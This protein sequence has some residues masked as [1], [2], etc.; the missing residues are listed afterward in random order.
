[1]WEAMM[2]Y[3]SAVNSS[4]HSRVDAW[5]CTFS[6]LSAPVKPAYYITSLTHTVNNRNLRTSHHGSVHTERRVLVDHIHV[7]EAKRVRCA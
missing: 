6:H 2:V 3:P 1:M 5:C 4:R 7:V